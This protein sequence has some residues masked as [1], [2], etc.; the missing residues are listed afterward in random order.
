MLNKSNTNLK[1]TKSNIIDIIYLDDYNKITVYQNNECY[2]MSHLRKIDGEVIEINSWNLNKY[3]KGD[4]SSYIKRDLNLFLVQGGTGVLNNSYNCCDMIYNYKEG[5]FII[6]KG[7]FDCIGTNNSVSGLVKYTSYNLDYLKKYG[8][9]LGYFK[10]EYPIEEDDIVT[11]IN[12]VT[13]EKMEY[14]FAFSSGLYFALINPDGKIRGNKLFR[15]SDFSKITEVINLD[16]YV[17]LKDFK[18]EEINKLNIQKNEIKKRSLEI[19]KKRNKINMSPY[20]D[21]EVIKVL[22]L[23]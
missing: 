15:G 20:L 18:K 8:C 21:E 14:S 9:F 17:S 3:S 2:T 11:Y 19:I 7:V 12:E 16:K 22:K 6:E 1:N 10:L 4:N 13:E 5:K 23:K